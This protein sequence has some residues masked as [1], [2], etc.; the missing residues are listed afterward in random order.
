M[1]YTYKVTII[2]TGQYYIGSQYSKKALPFDLG[3]S[4]FT[5]SGLVQNLIFEYGKNNVS[6]DILKIADK[7]S[8]LAEEYQLIKEHVLDPLCLNRQIDEK[9][10]ENVRNAHKS[11]SYDER[12]RN[13]SK[14]MKIRWQTPGFKEKMAKKNNIPRKTTDEE[15]EQKRNILKSLHER[16]LCSYN[17]TANTRWINNGIVNKR[18]HTTA[19]IPDG[20]KCGRC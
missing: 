19:S 15:R 17:H 8:C 9:F 2:P 4:Y 1:A 10:R 5:S 14:E 7:N 16:G 13:L 18:I 3:V 11:G 6:F 12:N 20:F